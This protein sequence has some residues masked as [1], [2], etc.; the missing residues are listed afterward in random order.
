MGSLAPQTIQCGTGARRSREEYLAEVEYHNNGQEVSSILNGL[1]GHTNTNTANH[2][3]IINV[4]TGRDC[5][6]PS[7]VDNALVY[8]CVYFL[9]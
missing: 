7:K 9:W 5:G 2:R 8:K 3:P 1:I 6:N 4:A